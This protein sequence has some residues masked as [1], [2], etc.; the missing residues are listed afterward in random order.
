MIGVYILYTM[1][2]ANAFASAFDLLP[3]SR[4]RCEVENADEAILAWAP[5]PAIGATL[6][7]CLPPREKH[8]QAKL[9]DG[10]PGKAGV[11]ASVKLE[12]LER[13]N[14]TG[15][16]WTRR[17]MNLMRFIQSQRKLCARRRKETRE[18]ASV[19][20]D[21]KN[22]SSAW[23]SA[24]PLRVGGLVKKKKEE[25]QEMWQH[26]NQ[27]TVAGVIKLGYSGHGKSSLQREG[28]DGSTKQASCT[29]VT[30]SIAAELQDRQLGLRLQKKCRG[31]VL[32]KHHDGTPIEV[33]FGSLQDLLLPCARFAH[34]GPDGLW[35]MLPWSEYCQVT[36]Q[37]IAPRKGVVEVFAQLYRCAW[38]DENNVQYRYKVL[39]PPMFLQVGNASTVHGATDHSFK[40]FSIDRLKELA[41]RNRFMM[42]HEAPDNVAYNRRHEGYT[43]IVRLPIN[44]WYSPGGCVAHLSRLN[45]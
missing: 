2:G 12:K 19:R 38:M 41:D 8:P 18:Q 36:K 29:A 3:C 32:S 40:N 14:Q 42:I 31:F 11:G 17:T 13:S 6:P 35:K 23:D 37:R 1:I 28:I 44:I 45:I 26:A 25:K 7:A 10:L 24:H 39:A 34:K 5:A 33:A 30:A 4:A 27:Y 9:P 15:C 16:T 43:A 21:Y 20:E 22:L